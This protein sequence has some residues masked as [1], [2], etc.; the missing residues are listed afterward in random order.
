MSFG[1]VQTSLHNQ[2]TSFDAAGEHGYA[3][4]DWFAPGQMYT[5]VMQRRFRTRLRRF[6]CIYLGMRGVHTRKPLVVVASRDVRLPSIQQ[7][8]RTK[9]RS[10]VSTMAIP[11]NLW[12]QPGRS[13]TRGCN[14]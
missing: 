2:E 10:K 11:R 13:R 6:R 8:R 9:R 14:K 7:R 5:Q 3:V 4:I 1:D 12:S